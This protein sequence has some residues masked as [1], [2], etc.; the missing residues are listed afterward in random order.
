M[1]KKVYFLLIIF[2]NKNTICKCIFQ[3][4]QCDILPEDL[5]NL[6]VKHAEVV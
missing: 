2:S 6:S 5:A 1:R 4:V 3:N